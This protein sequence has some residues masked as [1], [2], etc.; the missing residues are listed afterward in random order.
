LTNATAVTITYSGSCSSAPTTVAQGNTCLATGTYAGDANHTGSFNTAGLTI[1]PAGSSV[2]VTGGS[3]V[4]DGAAHAATGLASTT[5]GSLTNATA[6]AI[7]Y[8]GSCSSAPTTVAQGTSCLAT[9]T[10]AGDANHAGSSNTAGITITPAGSSVT[11]TGGSFPYDGAAHA[12]TGLASTAAGSLT[13]P[14][15]VGITYSG[16]C[17]SAPTTV[18]EGASCLAT[19]TY[20]GDANHLSSFNTANVVI[21]KGSQTITFTSMV[22]TATATSTGNVSFSSGTPANCSV[23]QVL[24][25][26][27]NPVVPGQALVT[28]LSGTW[29]NC[30]VLATQSGTSDYN[31][32]PQATAVLTAP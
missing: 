17:T 1:T 29:A 18:A 22:V 30:S 26:S 5:V 4:Y 10:Y 20:S 21:T 9:G 3:S 19:G 27:N 11:V 12:A 8:S 32:A 2:I 15:A 6:V 25:I 28:L 23:A 14:A 7:T 13:N 16:S 24:D 31:P